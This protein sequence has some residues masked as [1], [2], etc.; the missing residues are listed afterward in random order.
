[1]QG[2]AKGLK[3]RRTVSVFR[4]RLFCSNMSTYHAEVHSTLRGVAQAK[5]DGEGPIN[6]IAS[7]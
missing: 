5:M 2:L 3:N 1:V 7:Q 4:T 6:L